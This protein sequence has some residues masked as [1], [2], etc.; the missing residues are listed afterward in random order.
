MR[1]ER[2]NQ[3]QPPYQ[4]R[5]DIA[6]RGQTGYGRAYPISRRC[7]SPP[8]CRLCGSRSVRPFSAIYGRGTTFYTRIKGLIFK[9]GY[10]RTKR[11]SIMAANCSPP[12]KF[13]WSPAFGALALFLMA[14]WGST[15]MDRLSSFFELAAYWS[16]WAV[17]LLAVT[18][19]VTNWGFYPVRMDAWNRKFLCDKCGACT[20][21][22]K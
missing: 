12:S 8:C 3:L 18:A 15:N 5:R 6:R 9:H 10:E 1:E 11:Q 21:L 14:R 13:P 16:A 2:E 4:D 17:M 19:G 22:D 20:V 7:Y